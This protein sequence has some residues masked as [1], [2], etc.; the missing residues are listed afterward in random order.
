[1]KPSLV[2]VSVAVALHTSLPPVLTLNPPAS[3][4]VNVV[5]KVRAP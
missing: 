5:I 2:M 3:S 4:L 1:M